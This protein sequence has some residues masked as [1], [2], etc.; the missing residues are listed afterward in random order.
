MGTAWLARDRVTRDAVCLKVL[1][2]IYASDPEYVARFEREVELVRRIDSPRVVKVIG[3]GR[4]NGL[5]FI[6]MEYVDGKS[7][8]DLIRERG[9]LSWDEARAIALQVAEGLAAAHAVGI[10]HRD[11]K[12]SNILVTAKGEVKLT[13][14]GIARAAD[15]TAMSGGSTMLGTPHYMAPDDEESVRSDLYSLGCT[16]Y[17]MLTGSPPHPGD[18]HQRVIAAHFLESPNFAYVPAEAR[19]VVAWFLEKDQA[20]RPRDARTAC[21]ALASREPAPGRPADRRWLRFVGQVTSGVLPV[22][23]VFGGLAYL[24]RGSDSSTLGR[25]RPGRSNAPLPPALEEAS[26]V[27]ALA[28]GEHHA[29]LLRENGAAACWGTN[30]WGKAEVPPGTY[31][32][33][34]AGSDTTC[35][36]LGSGAIRCWGFPLGEPPGGSFTAVSVGSR[37][38]CALTEHGSVLCW[39][40]ASH[41]RTAAPDGPFIAVSAGEEH[42]CG[43]RPGG[44]AVCWGSNTA[45]RAAPPPLLLAAISA[46][47]EH[48]CGIDANTRSAVCWGF[49][50]GGLPPG[51]PLA[52]ISTRG[53]LICGTTVEGVGTCNGK[54]GLH[55]PPGSYTEIAA[56]G[57]YACGIESGEVR[58]WGS[59]GWGY[60]LPQ[61]AFVKL[62]LAAGWGCGLRSDGGVACWGI[63]DII[64]TPPPEGAFRD[65]AAGKDHACAL[66]LDNTVVCWGS[67]SESPAGTFAAIAADAGGTCAIRDDGTRALVCTGVDVPVIDGLQDLAFDGGRLC[68][69]TT[70]GEAA[71]A[72]PS[73]G[74]LPLD[75]RWTEVAVSAAH[76]CLRSSE[77]EVAC[78]KEMPGRVPSGTYRSL[79]VGEGFGCGLRDDGAIVCWGDATS[80]E[81]VTPPHGKFIAVAAEGQNA[82]GI[83][84]GNG[85]L[86]CWGVDGG[87]GRLVPPGSRP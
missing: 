3:I 85:T 40:D 18:A 73:P 45:G 22:L 78:S 46:G 14:F 79:A 33:I 52:S 4:A 53:E 39:G 6:A 37:H 55:P 19:R 34:S 32:A 13:D 8:R 23:I 51:A 82:C 65:V 72:R 21:L 7:L 48:S 86:V 20:R 87:W 24:V 17:E 59:P 30:A 57:E 83:R 81:A 66:R 31:R 71:C 29:C 63:T 74:P 12:P 27:I 5:P 38:A 35:A 26:P 41:G 42:T 70:E 60:S 68:Y 50:Q 47:R 25:D 77:G 44:V 76:T 61:G 80:V 10:L 43:L 84:D 67:V 56:G 54:D 1:H 58:C 75:G 2:D 64:R 69:I 11:V 49:V 36:I 28:T 15:L 62:A 16:L 9:R